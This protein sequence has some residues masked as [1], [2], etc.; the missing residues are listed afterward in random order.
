MKYLREVRDS[1]KFFLV[2]LELFAPVSAI[3][4]GMMSVIPLVMAGSLALALRSLPIA[5]YQSFLKQAFGGALERLLGFVQNGTLDI[6]SLLLTFA[7]AHAYALKKNESLKEKLSPLIV[8]I[9]ALSSF[10]IFRCAYSGESLITAFG[11][12]TVAGGVVAALLAPMLFVRLRRIQLF[13]IGV[14]SADAY[15][16]YNSSLSSIFPAM[17]TIALFALSAVLY[18]EFLAPANLTGGWAGDM[19][20]ALL[21]K[22]PVLGSALLFVFFVHL[23][24]CF[25][26][27]GNNVL[28]AVA[29]DLFVP[30]LQVNQELVASGQ[31]PTEIVT[32]TFLDTFVLMG[33]SGATLCLVAGILLFS[34]SRSERRLIKLSSLPLLLNVNELIIFGIPIV[35]NPVYF[36]P[37]TLLPVLL[38]ATSFFAV[39]V[40]LV[41]HTVNHVEW[42]TPVFVSGYIATG[43]FRGVALQLFNIVLG[44]LCYLPFIRLARSATDKKISNALDKAYDML[45]NDPL[46]FTMHGQTETADFLRFLALDLEND[47]QTEKLRLHYQPQVDHDGRVF[48]VEALLR[49]TH[50]NYGPVAPQLAVR[51]AESTGLIGKLGYWILNRACSD[52]ARV[53][54][55]GRTDIVFSI[56]V[57]PIQ[58]EDE[59]FAQTLLALIEKHAVDPAAL[60]IEITEESALANSARVIEQLKT[61]VQHGV[62]LAMD[63]FGMGHTSLKYMREYS[64]D[65]IKI[66]GSIVRGVTGDKKCA[67]IIASIVSLGAAMS[68]SVVAEF[69]ENE[70]QMKALQTLGCLQYQG[71]LFGKPVPF[72]EMFAAVQKEPARF[73]DLS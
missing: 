33:G 39:S 14:Y 60:K 71:Y 41:P 1:I 9:T 3:R 50:E 36:I 73:G 35:F 58:L 7:I 16:F 13:R 61:L 37:F 28:E 42:T 20:A 26:I 46:R 64:F 32:K 51:L 47:L 40:G 49:W 59:H 45:E 56:N 15:A 38:T 44:T 19:Y 69:V 8:S 23:M 70:E 43:S 30:A 57:S 17:T 65:T 2:E 48:G 63:D 67:D 29:Q 22:G 6:L 21:E 31:L 55:T 66:D 11:N 18:K 72:E 34:K 10:I 5:P 54:S 53:R 25:G 52:L 12:T 27:H 24:W 68:F 62:R 4:R